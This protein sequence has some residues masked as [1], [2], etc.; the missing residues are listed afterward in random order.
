MKKSQQT[1]TYQKDKASNYKN[2]WRIR[3][4][5]EKEMQMV[6]THAERCSMSSVPGPC[7]PEALGC[8]HHHSR[9]VRTYV[10]VLWF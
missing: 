2:W 7:K 10:S 3:Q 6:T 8:N 1:L 9:G 4:I 5:S